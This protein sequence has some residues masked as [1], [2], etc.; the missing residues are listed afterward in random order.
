MS[1]FAIRNWAFAVAVL[2]GLGLYGLGRI[3]QRR[4]DLITIKRLRRL[5]KET[6]Q[7]MS[8]LKRVSND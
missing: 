8:A 6:N 4:H 5:I 2:I 7:L 1:D 3:H